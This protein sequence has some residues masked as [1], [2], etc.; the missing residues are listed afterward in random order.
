MIGRRGPADAG[1]SREVIMRKRL[2]R[3]GLAALLLC[4]GCNLGLIIEPPNGNDNA[5]DNIDGAEH[6]A[7]FTDPDSDFSTSEVRDVDEEI[8]QFDTETEAIIWAADET[9][10][11]AGLWDVNGNF[12]AGGFFQVRFGTR[13]G[14]RRAYFTETAAATICQLRIQGGQLSVSATSVPVPQE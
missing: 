13:S 3:G 9:S 14:E 7:V 10:Y 12:L 5:N 2:G 1:M 8:V 6:R 11:D 4:G